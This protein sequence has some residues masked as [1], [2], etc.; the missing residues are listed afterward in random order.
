MILPSLSFP[1]IHRCPCCCIPTT[2]KRTP[3]TLSPTQRLCCQRCNRCWLDFT[4]S[5]IWINNTIA[6]IANHMLIFSLEG[7]L[8]VRKDK[9]NLLQSGRDCPRL[10]RE[11]Y[12]PTC[13]SKLGWSARK[14]T[15]Q[16]C[17]L[18]TLLDGYEQSYNVSLVSRFRL[19]CKLYASIFPLAEQILR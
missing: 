14:V 8:C 12:R 6:Q 2:E 16:S 7:C 15:G 19:A 10:C 5:E 3:P 18:I 9:L 4:S 11:T 13:R 1:A 17:S